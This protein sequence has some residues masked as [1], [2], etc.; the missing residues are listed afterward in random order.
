MQNFDSFHTSS[1]I[2]NILFNFIKKCLFILNNFL[3]PLKHLLMIQ[4][5][6][7]Y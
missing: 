5:I 4:L 2:K 7:I 6:E 1:N 3:H